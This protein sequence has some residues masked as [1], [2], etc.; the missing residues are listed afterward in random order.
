MGTPAEVA[1]ATPV[2]TIPVMVAAAEALG[3]EIPNKRATDNDAV[4]IDLV[5]FII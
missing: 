1:D 2:G 5:K 4:A 3:T